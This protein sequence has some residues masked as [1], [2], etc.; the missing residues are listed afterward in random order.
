MPSI[1]ES[2]K[3]N[4]DKQE[5]KVKVFVYGTLKK[6]FGNHHYYLKDKDVNFLG[7][8]YLNDYSLYRVWVLPLAIKEKGKR[9]KGEVYEVPMSIFT[10]LYFMEIGAGYHVDYIDD[11]VLFAYKKE[12]VG[13]SKLLEIG[14]VFKG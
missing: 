7:E 8:G 14:E 2:K 4:G 12:K 5:S 11:V 3:E 1:S 10:L 9:I 13:C 6:G